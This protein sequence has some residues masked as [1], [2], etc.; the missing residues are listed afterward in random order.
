M[1]TQVELKK[2]FL[3]YSFLSFIFKFLVV[4]WF[5]LS[6]FMPHK[7]SICSYWQPV[8]CSSTGRISNWVPSPWPA[9]LH[10]QYIVI[11]IILTYNFSQVV[12]LYRY[13]CM[14]DCK[15]NKRRSKLHKLSYKKI[16]VKWFKLSSFCVLKWSEFVPRCSLKPVSY[17]NLT[18]LHV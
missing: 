1:K 6:P 15:Y 18:V 16:Q 11:I 2:V 12:S 8:H 3:K 9:C 4:V 10:N 5:A 17:W 7:N 13:I 14:C